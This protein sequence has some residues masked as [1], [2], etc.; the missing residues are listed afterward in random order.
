MA[1]G[2]K[3]IAGWFQDGLDQK[4]AYMIVVCDT[5]DH[6]DYPVYTNDGEQFWIKHD[7]VNGQNMQRIMEVYDLNQSWQSQAD[8]RVMNTPPRPAPRTTCSGVDP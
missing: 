5:F 3:E 8:G 4:A 1:A 6:D 7:A 2:I